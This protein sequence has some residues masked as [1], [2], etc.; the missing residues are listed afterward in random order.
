M[1]NRGSERDISER[2][3]PVV[4]QEARRLLSET[5]LEADPELLAAGWERRF[6]ADRQRASEAM[7]LYEQLGYEVCTRALGPHE[8]GDECEDC[9]L[10]ALLQFQTIY[11]RKRERE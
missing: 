2:M 3:G 4:E 5:Q 10:V 9:K 6:V 8:L 1:G 11:T 7:E